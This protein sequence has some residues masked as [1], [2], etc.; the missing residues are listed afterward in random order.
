M[1]YLRQSTFDQQD[2][3]DTTTT[4]TTATIARSFIGTKSPT[5]T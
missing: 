1:Q 4:M 3:L 5:S 2:T